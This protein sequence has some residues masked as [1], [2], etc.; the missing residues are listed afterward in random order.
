MKF[1]EK[2]YPH[3]AA[4]EYHFTEAPMP[5]DQHMIPPTQ[6]DIENRNP[7]WLKDKGDRFMHD[8]NYSAAI[9]V[10]SEALSIDPSQTKI[11]M[12]RSLAHMKSLNLDSAINDCDSILI[13]MQKELVNNQD[14]KSESLKDL[15]KIKTRK[16]LCTAWKGK[17]SEAK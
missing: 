3:V 16:A 11:K 14:N 8:R 17:F 12:N 15:V 4:R 1:T 2:V 9:D 6:G 7:L 10:Y 5:K 13:Q